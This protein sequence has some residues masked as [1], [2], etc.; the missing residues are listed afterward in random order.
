MIIRSLSQKMIRFYQVEVLFLLEAISVF[1]LFQILD[2][3]SRFEVKKFLRFLWNSVTLEAKRLSYQYEKNFRNRL[4]KNKVI[5][6]LSSTI[7][8]VNLALIYLSVIN[9]HTLGQLSEFSAH[10]IIALYRA[11]VNRQ[12]I[13]FDRLE[14]RFKTLPSFWLIMRGKCAAENSDTFAFLLAL[15]FCCC[16]FARVALLLR[17]FVAFLLV[18]A[19]LLTISYCFFALLLLCSELYIAFL[20]CCFVAVA[21]LLVLLFCSAKTYSA[22]KQHK[23]KSNWAS[24][25]LLFCSENLLLYCSLPKPKLKS[26]RWTRAR[27]FL[28]K[29]EIK[30]QFQGLAW[31][32]LCYFS[33]TEKTS[34]KGHWYKGQS[35][36]F[37]PKLKNDK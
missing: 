26:S 34:N 1:F 32:A 37:D 24:N 4:T 11:Q 7:L 17:Q 35:H 33:Y 25:G 20:R 12:K 6:H 10:R 30:L 22:T 3:E 14:S 13:V 27:F 18:V 23:Q 31:K 28:C 36:L 19:C 21:F 5:A 29:L 16:F 15:L 8:S 9:Y 2:F